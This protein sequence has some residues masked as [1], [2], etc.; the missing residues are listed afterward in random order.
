M[1]LKE[2]IE[3]QDGKN[4]ARIQ[5]AKVLSNMMGV[6]TPQGIDKAMQDGYKE[7]MKLSREELI[8]KYIDSLDLVFIGKFKEDL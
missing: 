3:F 6:T 8:S 5:R 1:N 4:K 7:L 2:M